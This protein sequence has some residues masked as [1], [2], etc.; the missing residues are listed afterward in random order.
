M[1]WGIT[2]TYQCDKFERNTSGFANSMYKVAHL[3]VNAD[4]IAEMCGWFK[5][6]KVKEIHNEK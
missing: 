4:T 6:I 3:N 2:K 5:P 1:N